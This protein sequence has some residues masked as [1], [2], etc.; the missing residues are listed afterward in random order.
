[1]TLQE[2]EEKVSYLVNSL[3][4]NK[5]IVGDINKALYFRSEPTFGDTNKTQEE[6][7][8][9]DGYIFRITK[10]LNIAGKIVDNEWEI[11]NDIQNKLRDESTQEVCG[12]RH[13]N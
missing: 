9:E 2:V 13:S 6:T 4:R 7:A 1:M 3:D 5:E 11:L 10:L 12:A 8:T